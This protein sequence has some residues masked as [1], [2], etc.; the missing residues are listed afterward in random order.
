MREKQKKRHVLL[1]MCLL[2]RG[3][4]PQ[5][6]KDCVNVLLHIIFLFSSCNF[7]CQRK[8]SEETHQTLP[9]LHK[10]AHYEVSNS[11]VSI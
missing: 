6:P 9:T 4:V 5:R 11:L 7:F 8:G 3:S 1:H 2:K 10:T